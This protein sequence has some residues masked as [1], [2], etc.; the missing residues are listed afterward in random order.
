M[1]P[2]LGVLGTQL[3]VL[4]SYGRLLRRECRVF[5]EGETGSSVLCGTNQLGS[6]LKYN[7]L[8]KVSDQGTSFASG[9]KEASIQ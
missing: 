1:T 2:D 3:Q 4:G 7:E 6:Y 5:Q 8:W 9:Q